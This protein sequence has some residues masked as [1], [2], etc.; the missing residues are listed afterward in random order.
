MRLGIVGTGHVGLVT[1]VGFASLGHTV[2]GMDKD[3]ERIARL[4]R[5]EPILYEPGLGDLLQSTLR[6]GRLR[7]T[8]STAEM[9]D[10][11]DIVFLCVGTPSLR[12]GRADLSQVEEAVGG[13]ACQPDGFK[14]IVEKS[15]VPVG[16]GARIARALGRPV[17]GLPRY[18][19]ASNPE[20]LR[21]G[22]AVHDFLHPDRIVIGA[23][24]DRARTLLREL[25]ERDFDCPILLTSLRAAE[26]IKHA[27]NAFLATKISFIN[28][29]ADFCD[30]V[31][32]DVSDV[33]RAI[34]LDPRIGPHFLKAGLGYGG[35]CFS[36]D[37]KAFVWSAVDAGLDFSLLR[38]VERINIARVARL[39][40]KLDEAL[41]GLP[42]KTVGVLG[43]AFKADTDDIREAP[44]LS[45]IARLREAGAALRV[46]DPRAARK[47][48]DLWPP[49]DTLAYA[50]SAYDAAREAH[51]LAVLTD[52][53]EFRSV[54]LERLRRVMRAPVVVDGRN[55][56]EPAK[57]R[58]HGFEYHSLG[59][60]D[61]AA[62]P[63]AGSVLASALDGRDSAPVPTP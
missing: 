35:S 42:G 17:A 30:H 51:A 16:T 8:T 44:S 3:A 40:Q 38:E 45:V 61:A 9:L 21:E 55:L 2:V 48:A 20:F 49:D 37:L 14:L 10:G 53:D 34:G 58:A 26:L 24:S 46:Y 15:T 33:A 57:M 22:S 18:E 36:K 56:F 39:L 19:V 12:D 63:M 13:I 4:A 32:A 7:F 62:A 59:R 47:L 5:G 11:S 28:M 54:D 25:Y 1:A 6:S 29:V 60:G 52:W 50:E 41:G 31:G 27:A 43:A 23:D